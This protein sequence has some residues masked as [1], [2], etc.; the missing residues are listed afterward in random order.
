M[1]TKLIDGKEYIEY[2]KHRA[3]RNSAIMQSVFLILIAIAIGFLISGIFEIRN[4]ADALKFPLQY[5]LDRFG[6]KE[7]SCQYWDGNFFTVE[8]R[9]NKTVYVPPKLNYTF[10]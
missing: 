1:E 10:P 4:N 8:S 3:A 5:N 9:L 2:D 6:I 7:C